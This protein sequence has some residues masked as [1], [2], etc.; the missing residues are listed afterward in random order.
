[1]S[2]R[3]QR[4]SWND[5]ALWKSPATGAALPRRGR[6]SVVHTSTRACW[7]A[8]VARPNSAKR[9]PCSIAWAPPP[10]P[11]HCASRCAS[12]GF[13]AYPAAHG[14]RPSRYSFGL[15]R[16][17]AEILQSARR[18][19]PAELRR[20]RKATVRLPTKTVRTTTYLSG[21][22]DQTRRAVARRGRRAGA[23]FARRVDI[24]QIP[25][26]LPRRLRLEPAPRDRTLVTL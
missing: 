25:M 3:R 6:R 22:S 13:A 8:T 10:W 26:R 20:D 7:R 15:T 9:S 17:E 24:T 19:D 18:V 2:R 4:K 11:P 16:R 5:R 14:R 1:M 23:Q 12:E 21:H